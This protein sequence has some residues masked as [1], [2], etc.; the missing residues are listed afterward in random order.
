M[1]QRMDSDGSRSSVGRASSGIVNVNG[2][3]V[4]RGLRIAAPELTVCSFAQRI[5]SR[6]ERL[7]PAPGTT[8]RMH[9]S[10]RTNPLSGASFTHVKEAPESGFVLRLMCIR[11]VVPG[12][13]RSRSTREEI[14][15]AN[16]Q[17]VSS[18]AAM[19]NPL[20]TRVPFTFTIPDDARPTDERDPSESI[21]WRIAV[22]AEVPGIDYAADFQFP[23]VSTGEEPQA[24]G[25]F[26]LTAAA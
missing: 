21:L 20:G 25:T 17:T 6:V 18:G 13:G 5:S 16:E 12:A 7:R 24:T 8:R 23:V 22:K 26:A 1:R 9:M 19:R 2:T 11:R 4:P 14:L 3:R 10:R 15:W